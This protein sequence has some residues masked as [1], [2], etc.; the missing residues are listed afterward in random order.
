LSSALD[1]VWRSW[2]QTKAW[3]VATA[4]FSG[5]AKRSATVAAAVLKEGRS[6]IGIFMDGCN[7]DRMTLGLQ[8]YRPGDAFKQVPIFL[9]N[10]NSDSIAGPQQVAPVVESMRKSGFT[11]LRAENYDGGHQLNNEQL[12]S[13]LRW[14][15][16]SS[17]R[18]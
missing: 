10:G 13:A 6:V 16:P 11:N 17:L 3:P 15:R 12:V 14:F 5:G 9:S 2:P 18:R 4:G 7:E 1:F 8:L